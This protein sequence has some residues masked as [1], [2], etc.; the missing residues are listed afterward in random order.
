MKKTH[1][2]AGKEMSGRMKKNR[3]LLPILL[4]CGIPSLQ[5]R[6]FS[7]ARTIESNSYTVQPGRGPFRYAH[8]FDIEEDQEGKKALGLFFRGRTA[9]TLRLNEPL[10]LKG[11][12]TSLRLRIEGFHGGETVYAL[13]TDRRGTSHRI[14]VGRT[15]FYGFQ[16]WQV[17]LQ[18]LAFRPT[19]MSEESYIDFVGWS[20][21]PDLRQPEAT[22]YLIL[23]AP[24]FDVRPFDMR[25]PL[26]EENNA[27]ADYSSE[28][29]RFFCSAYSS[30]VI[31]PASFSSANFF[32]RSATS[33]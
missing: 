18:H 8:L 15:D 9:V 24:V 12:T 30:S 14:A 32:R 3:L 11:F 21:E 33:F 17:Q 2:D 31:S 5:A 27:R 10:R 26:L 1:I 29:I 22:A 25:I 28:R 7:D 13:F 16:E 20:I 6:P 23:R 19:R 4:L